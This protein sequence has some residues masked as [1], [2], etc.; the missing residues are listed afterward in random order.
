MKGDAFASRTPPTIPKK[1]MQVAERLA[2]EFTNES[3][4]DREVLATATTDFLQSQLDDARRRLA[5]QEAKVA[6]FQR[7]HAGQLPSERESEPAGHAQPAAAGPGPARLGEPR[8]GSAPVPGADAGRSG[9]RRPGRP[10][11]RPLRH[12]A[13]EAAA[14]RSPRQARP[15]TGWRPRAR[16]SRLSSCT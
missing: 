9:G 6:D 5:E 11:A 7:R 14:G 12:G 2:S 16:R 15:P 1:A 8:P 4:Q 10:L 13:G 3:L